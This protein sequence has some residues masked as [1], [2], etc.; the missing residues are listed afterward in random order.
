MNRFRARAFTLLEVMIV[1]GLVAILTSLAYASY[2]EI[3]SR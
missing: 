2:S 1:V 3:Q